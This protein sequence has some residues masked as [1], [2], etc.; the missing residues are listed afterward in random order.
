MRDSISS[1]GPRPRKPRPDLI[2]GENLAP[3]HR[4]MDVE[5]LKRRLGVRRKTS[6]VTRRSFDSEISNVSPE[7]P[8]IPPSAILDHE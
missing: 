2:V 1:I 5:H 6:D 3:G 8:G 4:K 7:F